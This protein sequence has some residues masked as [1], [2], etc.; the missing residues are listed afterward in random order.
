MAAASHAEILPPPGRQMEATAI[1]H[2]PTARRH[3][4][5]VRDLRRICI[6]GVDIKQGMMSKD[7]NGIDGLPHKTQQNRWRDH[8]AFSLRLLRKDYK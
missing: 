5:P 7:V 3:L 2:F 4:R 6:Y 8:V 1:V